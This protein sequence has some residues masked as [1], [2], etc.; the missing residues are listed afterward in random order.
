ML[1]QLTLQN[2]YQSGS[3]NDRAPRVLRARTRSPGGDA[4]RERGA[5][6][7]V[8]GGTHTHTHTHIHTRVMEVR[9]R[10]PVLKRR[11]RQGGG[12]E[13]G[14]LLAEGRRARAAAMTTRCSREGRS[15]GRRMCRG[16]GRRWC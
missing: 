11:V 6:A 13:G 8:V 3:L 1:T 9:R 10:A 2:F 16:R 5:T 15:G 4:G 12:G 7:K 14:L